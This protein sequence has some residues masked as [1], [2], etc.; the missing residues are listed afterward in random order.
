MTKEDLLS[1]R[2]M[3]NKIKQYREIMDEMLKDIALPKAVAADGMPR[4]SRKEQDPLAAAIARYLERSQEYADKVDELDKRCRE[5]EMSIDSLPEPEQEV[6]R[7]RYIMGLMWSDIAHKAHRSESG[8]Y[9]I[10]RRALEYLEDVEDLESD[11]VPG[12]IK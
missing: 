1:Y 10:H 8:L 2:R 11:G 4:G 6:C 12:N 9:E 7:Y 5:I 3:T